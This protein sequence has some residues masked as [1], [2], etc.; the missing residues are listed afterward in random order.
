MQQSSKRLFSIIIS[1]AFAVFA[2]L[3]L[4]EFIEPAYGDLMTAKG[5]LVSDK[6]YLA[7]EQQTVSQAQ[8]LLSTVQSQSGTESALE[9]AMPSG[10]DV[11]GAL[12]QVYG[13]AANDGIAIQ[14]MSVSPPTVQLQAAMGASGATTLAAIVKPMGDVSFQVTATG[15]YENFATF[16][17]DLESN[18]RIFDMTSFSLQQGATAGTK[19]GSGTDLFTYSF[20]VETYYQLQ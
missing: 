5:Q 10:P 18:V 1:L 8:S 12:A 3:A 4:F 20:T 6:A 19:G 9:L 7:T 14:N 16:L 17:A 15:S 2:L 13:I 11:S